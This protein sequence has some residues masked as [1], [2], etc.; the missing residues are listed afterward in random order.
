MTTNGEIGGILLGG[1][2]SWILIL[3]VIASVKMTFKNT[4]EWDC[5]PLLTDSK[6]LYSL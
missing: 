5:D 2:I 3:L 1:I 4:N 6:V